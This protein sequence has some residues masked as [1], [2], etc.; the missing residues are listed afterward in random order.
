M[1]D[2]LIRRLDADPHMCLVDA[3]ELLN[4][5]VMRIYRRADVACHSTGAD[6]GVMLELH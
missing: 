2:E 1:G 3:M 5:K 6:Q 4:A